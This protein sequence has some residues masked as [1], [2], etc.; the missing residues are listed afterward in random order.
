M[1]KLLS[2]IL[3]ENERNALLKYAKG[4]KLT[5]IKLIVSLRHI[6]CLFE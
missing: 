6:C 1:D 4:K 5:L 2:K 3:K